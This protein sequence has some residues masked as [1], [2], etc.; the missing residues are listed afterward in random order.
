MATTA[1]ATKILVRFKRF[2]FRKG[3]LAVL[4]GLVGGGARDFNTAPGHALGALRQGLS[5]GKTL[6]VLRRQATGLLLWYDAHHEFTRRRRMTRSVHG[7]L[8]LMMLFQYAVWGFW[9]PVLARFLQ[10]APA[11]GGL[12]F[13]PGQVGWILG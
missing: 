11:E 1:M 4:R 8:S 12:G 10:A 9:L 3:R 13:T 5:L 2:S 6:R 7:R